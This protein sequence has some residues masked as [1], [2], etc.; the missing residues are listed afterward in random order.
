MDLFEASDLCEL[1]VLNCS[2]ADPFSE[3]QGQNED[4]PAYCENEHKPRNSTVKHVAL[5][6]LALPIDVFL[7]V[8]FA[9]LLLV[10]FFTS[11]ATFL[12]FAALATYNRQESPESS[13]AQSPSALGK[14][15]AQLH[16]TQQVESVEDRRR[17][18]LTALAICQSEAVRSGIA[19]CSIPRNGS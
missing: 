17:S 19:Q 13:A 2:M 18:A 8:V 1:A 11:T 16:A 12:S 7:A 14:V 10:E 6:V 3:S 15:S 9:P 4:W 5:R